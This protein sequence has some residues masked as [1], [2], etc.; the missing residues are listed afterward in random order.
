MAVQRN[1][2]IGRITSHV[3][4]AC[5]YISCRR[6]KTEQMLIDFSDVLCTP[7]RILG[8]VRCFCVYCSVH[9]IKL[10]YVCVYVPFNFLFK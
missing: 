2:T 1:F 4:A 3:A 6:E 7:V 9:I 5:L 8:R 10:F